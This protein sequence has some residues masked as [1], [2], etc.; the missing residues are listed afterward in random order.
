MGTKAEPIRSLETGVIKKLSES[1][2][3]ICHYEN[4]EVELPFVLPGE[5]VQYE[6]FVKNPKSKRSQAKYFLKEITQFSSNRVSPVCAHFT[7]CGGCLLQ[8]LNVKM[9]E[10]FKRSLIVEPFIKYMIDTSVIQ[11]F[12]QE[13]VAELI[14]KLSKNQMELD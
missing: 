4:E 9:Y 5:T 6:R 8:H 7:E 12:L 13:N 1:G 2:V 10:S 14:L 3:G 11:D